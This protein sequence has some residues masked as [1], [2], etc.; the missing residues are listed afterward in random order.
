MNIRLDR[1]PG[2]VF[3]ALTLS[4]DDGK[5]YDRRMIEIMNQHGIK[6]TF[7][8]NSGKLGKDNYIEGKE[9][10]SL[11]AGHE[12]SAHT[13]DHPF[14]ELTPK[15]RVALEILE[16]RRSLE[17]LVN[18][19]IR[20]MS[21]PFGTYDKS[22]KAMLPMLGI[23]YART[24]N[25]HGAFTLPEDF[26]EWHPTCHHKDMFN[27][28]EPF[29]SL[30]QK[31]PK[32]ALFYVWGHSYEFENNENWEDLEKFCKRMGKQKDI[33][34]ATNLEIVDYVNGVKALRFSV[35]QTMVYNPTATTVWIGANGETVKVPAGKQVNLA[36]VEG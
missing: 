31:F 16:D 30:E 5:E 6:G 26:L 28:S 3:K 13:V 22:V 23:E 7:H 32:M 29:L 10:A 33:W 9:I 24:V 35:S 25:S 14:L 17:A 4:Y 8:L 19:P 1:F 27:Y 34:Y 36:T 12:V 15:E 2:G 11:F 21:Y 18:Y 20:G